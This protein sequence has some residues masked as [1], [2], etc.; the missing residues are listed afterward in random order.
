MAG[1][2]EGGHVKN[3]ADLGAPAANMALA[4]KLAAVV[5]EWG[6]TPARSEG[7]GINY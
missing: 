7:S 1:C 2:D 4:T 6:A 5:I 3:A